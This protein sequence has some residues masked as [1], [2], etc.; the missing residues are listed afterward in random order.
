MGAHNAN[1]HR[2]RQLRARVLAEETRC[3][4]CDEPVD[5]TLGKIPG[6]HTDACRGDCTGCVWHPRSPVV[7]EIIPRARGGDPL[8]RANTALSHRDCNQIKA[9]RS[10]DWARAEIARRRGDRPARATTT[11]LVP[12]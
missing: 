2:R 7:D 4:I 8:D 1:G 9:T 11:T 3:V 12:W 5:K 6:R 10:L